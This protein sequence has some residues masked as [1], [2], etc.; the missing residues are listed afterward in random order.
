MRLGDALEG[1]LGCRQV[2]GVFWTLNAELFAKCSRVGRVQLQTLG[3][4]AGSVLY[5]APLGVLWLRGLPGGSLRGCIGIDHVVEV[6]IISSQTGQIGRCN[7]Q[8]CA[9]CCRFGLQAIVPEHE[10]SIPRWNK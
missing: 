7:A 9:H 4:R 3:E 10:L 1:G 6:T 5:R 8:T 2:R